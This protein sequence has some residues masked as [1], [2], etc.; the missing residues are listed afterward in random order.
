LDD[1]NSSRISGCSSEVLDGNSDDFGSYLKL[2][3]TRLKTI[4][5]DRR[6]EER[7]NQYLT[8]VGAANSKQL[9]LLVAF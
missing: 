4:E 3:K 2:G 9:L 7:G 1:E 6:K 5:D 8:T